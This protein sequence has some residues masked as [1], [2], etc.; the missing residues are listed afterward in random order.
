MRADLEAKD[1]P[2]HLQYLREHNLLKK[3]NLTEEGYQELLKSQD[4]KCG[5]CKSSEA[6]GRTTSN[7]FHVDHDHLTGKFRG[8]LCSLC[9]LALGHWKDDL[10][11]LRRAVDYLEKHNQ[12]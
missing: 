3:Y 4:Y 10:E 6:G 12:E 2:R 1:R 8:L 7:K 5:L 11:R 9:N